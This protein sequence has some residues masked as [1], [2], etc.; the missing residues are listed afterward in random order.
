M[1]WGVTSSTPETMPCW[2]NIKNALVRTL[3]RFVMYI[4]C[5][6]WDG[7]VYKECSE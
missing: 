5:Y 3:Q 1:E 2:N 6:I 7:T 4:L